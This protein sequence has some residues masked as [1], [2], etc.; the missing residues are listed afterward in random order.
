[1]AFSTKLKIIDAKMEQPSGGTL[2]L[3]GN[4]TVADSGDL[5]YESHPTF[6]DDVQIIDKKYV[7]DNIVSGGTYSLSSPSTTTVGGLTAGSTLTGKTSNELLEEILVPYLVPTFSSFQINGQ[8]TTVEVGTSISGI[9]PFIWATTNSGNVATN[10]IVIRDVTAASNIATGLANDGGETVDVGTINFT[11]NGQTQS[12]RGQGTDTQA[13]G[14]NSSN[15]TV[16]SIHPY[17]YGKVTAAGPAGSG[18]PTA[19]NALVTGGTKVVGS[20]TGTITVVFNSTSD[21][22]IW[23]AIP[24]TSTSKTKWYETELNQGAIGGSV[25]PGG[26]LF[27]DFDTVAITTALWGPVNFKVYIANYQS[28]V[29]T[30][31]LRNS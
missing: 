14:F 28:G 15:F 6:V 19:T 1:M 2:T 7:D 27:P 4:T 11:S 10:S 5:R 29:G 20:S 13:G 31:Q 21:Q 9:Q 16:T 12:W 3:S 18:R 22:Y 25:S 26:N 24:S 17:F 23:F 8:S 30:L